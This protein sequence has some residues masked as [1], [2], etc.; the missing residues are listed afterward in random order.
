[1]QG[2]CEAPVTSMPCLPRRTARARVPLPDF[3]R[4]NGAML[5]T[6]SA[7]ASATSTATPTS[8]LRA[9]TGWTQ[10][11]ANGLWGDSLDAAQNDFA[12]RMGF[13][14]HGCPL[15]ID[16][17][18]L[19]RLAPTPRISILVH[20]LCSNESAWLFRPERESVSETDYGRLL[21]ADHGVT[22]FY[23]RYNTGLSVAANGQALSE[24]IEL[25]LRNYPMRVDDITL[26]G[27]SMG[28]LVLRAA[29]AAGTRAHRLWVGRVREIVYLGTPHEGADLARLARAASVTLRTIPNPVTRL[30]GRILDLRSAGVRDLCD[31]Y[32]D[33]CDDPQGASTAADF[34]LPSANHYLI[35]GTVTQNPRH[36]AAHLLGDG[37]VRPPRST[38][39]SNTQ[40]S[41]TS[42]APPR[43]EH[44]IVAGANHLGLLGD[45][46]VY[47][48]IQSWCAR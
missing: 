19:A 47:D 20:G 30:I 4:Y 25:L 38:P 34:W 37:L 48:Q 27:H 17:E 5:E 35:S 40:R 43:T 22:P 10:S 8:S 11:V 12:I 3:T 31:G 26:I 15:P 32:D 42:A 41:H 1:M 33:R 21:Q 2:S 28:G 36:I 7:S 16:R 29:C 39:S 14:A 24:W 6:T 23:L 44:R 18:S 45:L 13:F 46:R 9:W